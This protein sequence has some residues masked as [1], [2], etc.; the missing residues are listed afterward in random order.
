MMRYGNQGMH[1]ADTR[2]CF[3]APTPIL[4]DTVPTKHGVPRQ[5]VTDRIRARVEA[6]QRGGRERRVKE[7]N[8]S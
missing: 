7:R 8:K 5:S 4:L 1:K 3:A 6:W 2:S